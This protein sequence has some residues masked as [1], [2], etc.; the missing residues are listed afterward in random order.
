MNRILIIFLFFIIYSCKT[1]ESSYP[2]KLATQVLNSNF[3]DINGVFEVN[4]PATSFYLD[5]IIK[6]KPSVYFKDC[7][8]YF[9]KEYFLY[10]EGVSSS[11][12]PEYIFHYKCETEEKVV[13]FKFIKSGSIW[14]LNEII[15]FDPVDRI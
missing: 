15:F 11:K 5:S 13:K 4:R 10:I 7:K 9:N 8:D 2:K 3:K 6:R 1:S 14:S 12:V